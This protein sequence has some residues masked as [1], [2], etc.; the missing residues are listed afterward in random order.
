[1]IEE[2]HKN[3]SCL[4]KVLFLW[5]NLQSRNSAVHFH[6]ETSHICAPA[7][8]DRLKTRCI[9]IHDRCVKTRK[10]NLSSRG[11]SILVNHILLAICVTSH[12]ERRVP[13]FHASTEKQICSTI[14]APFYNQTALMHLTVSPYSL[15]AVL[16]C[17][18]GLLL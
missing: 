16:R 9:I 3:S 5:L 4:S 18:Q 8:T 17:L 10:R 1:M 13:V 12:N 15:T 6:S 7:V 11:A 2:A 14:R